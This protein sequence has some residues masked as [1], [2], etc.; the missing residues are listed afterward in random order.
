[1]GGE[2]R[3]AAERETVIDVLI[4]FVAI[5]LGVTGLFAGLM[6]GL[7]SI[8]PLLLL[9]FGIVPLIVRIRQFK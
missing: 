9:I 4:G 2:S 7:L 1:M 6:R 3:M 5:V 8:M